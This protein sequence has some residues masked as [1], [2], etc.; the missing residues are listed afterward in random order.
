M[1]NIETFVEKTIQASRHLSLCLLEQKYYGSQR[2]Q[3]KEGEV[4]PVLENFFAVYG[5]DQA[6]VALEKSINQMRRN[7]MVRDKHEFLEL[8]IE[9]AEQ[10]MSVPPQF[11]HA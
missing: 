11:K 4:R 5:D 3:V 1:P 7:L 9:T 2:V 6:F 8:L 10:M